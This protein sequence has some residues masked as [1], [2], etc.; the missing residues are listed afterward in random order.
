MIIYL[1]FIHWLCDFVL[2]TRWQ[3]NNKSHNMRALFNHV[4]TY[5]IVMVVFLLPFMG[6]KAFLFGGITFLGHGI[7]DYFTSRLNKHLWLNR[8]LYKDSDSFKS[9]EY[10]KLFWISIGFD[11]FLHSLQL[12]L[13]YKW[14]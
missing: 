14:I 12:I 1:F 6:V 8:E 9:N 4:F 5:S 13:T 11:Q 7:T 10:E 3:G 2:Q